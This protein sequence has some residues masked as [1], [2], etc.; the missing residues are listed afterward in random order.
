MSEIKTFTIKKTVPGSVLFTLSPIS[1]QTLKKEIYLTSR[2]PQQVLP[3]DW[4]LGIFL[5]NSIYSLYKQGIF[6]FNDNDAV[7]KAAQEAGV[8]FDETLDFTP[9]KEDSTPKILKVLKSGVRADILKAIK[10]YGDDLVKNVVIQHANDL[11]TGVIGM[12]ENHWH[13][14]L[15]MDGDA[16]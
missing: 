13:I 10:D 8:Y 14:Q 1:N 9:V 7:V 4:A 15:T 3:L 16:I 5:D 11:T 6:T 2:M 12:L